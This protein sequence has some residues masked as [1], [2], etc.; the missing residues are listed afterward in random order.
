M[1]SFEKESLT[2]L[3]FEEF[4][5]NIGKVLMIQREEERTKDY[6]K[7]HITKSR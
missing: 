2:A 6:T 5:E 7:G 1:Y 4:H 3:V